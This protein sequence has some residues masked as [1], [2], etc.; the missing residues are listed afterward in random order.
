MGKK[1]KAGGVKG[2]ALSEIENFKHKDLQRACVVRGMP[3]D[4]VVNT[5]TPGLSNWF[6]SNYGNGQDPNLLNMFDGWVE[7]KLRELGRDEDDPIMTPCLRLGYI[8]EVDEETGKTIIKRLRNIKKPGKEKR[9]RDEVTNI[10][11][12]TKKALTYDCA[13]KLLPMNETIDIVTKQFP[14]AVEKSIRIWYGK[15]KKE[16]A[17]AGKS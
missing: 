2:R 15:A 9:E 7:E 17:N 16:Y 10:F 5:T 13:K 8:G 6:I 3:F 4:D 12:G 1:N 11:L 14:E